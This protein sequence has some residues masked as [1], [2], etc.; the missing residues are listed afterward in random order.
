MLGEKEEQIEDE[1]SYE[2]QG[3]RPLPTCLVMVSSGEV[4]L[5]NAIFQTPSVRNFELF[6]LLVPVELINTTPLM[7]TFLGSRL[8]GNLSHLCP[9]IPLSLSS[10]LLG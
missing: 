3:S 4:S 5:E 7:L 10:P 1:Q 9:H 2:S 6:C 8:S